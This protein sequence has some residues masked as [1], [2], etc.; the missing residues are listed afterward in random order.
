MIIIYCLS[1]IIYYVCGIIIKIMEIKITTK[2]VLQVLLILS[3][4]IFIGLCVEAGG[5]LFNAVFTLFV[6]PAGENFFW[7]GV[8]LTGLFDFDKGYFLTETMLMSIVAILQAILFYLI[9]KILHNKKL[10]L[11]QP[12]NRDMQRFISNLCYLS[13]GI[14]LFC[15]WGVG[16]TKWLAAKG[17]SMPDVHSLGFGGADVWVFMGIVLL[18]IAQ[19]FKRGVEIQT[20]NDLTI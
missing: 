3:W 7:K 16:N 19:V 5:I 20:E 11:T 1:I 18:V 9:V 17:I 4:I 13:L 8:N 15:H 2:Q 10:D 12:F 6:K 14:G